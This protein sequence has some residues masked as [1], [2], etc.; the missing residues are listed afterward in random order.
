MTH[1]QSARHPADHGFHSTADSH[2]KTCHVY[3]STH[4]GCHYNECDITPANQPTACAEKVPHVFK[5]PFG[6]LATNQV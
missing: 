2:T 3:K 5:S 1:G 4:G 6:S